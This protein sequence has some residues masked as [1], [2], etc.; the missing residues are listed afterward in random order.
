M[1]SKLCHVK[2]IKLTFK[3]ADFKT[4]FNVNFKGQL[5]H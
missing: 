5:I 4:G 1:Q 3:E 2:T